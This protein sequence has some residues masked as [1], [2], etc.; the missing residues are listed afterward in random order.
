MKIHGKGDEIYERMLDLNR[1]YQYLTSQLKKV[2]VQFRL[3][4]DIV[5][6]NIDNYG[7]N[8]MAKFQWP[9]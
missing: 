3:V 4:L 5:F 6:P 2:K 7:G 8:S 9:Y 1:H